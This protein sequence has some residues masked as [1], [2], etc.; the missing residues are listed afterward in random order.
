MSAHRLSECAHARCARVT[1]EEALAL[2]VVSTL[3]GAKLDRVCEQS[4]P[5][6]K[7][8]FRSIGPGERAAVEVKRLTSGTMQRHNNHRA[9]YLG[10]EPF[11]PAPTLMSTWLVFVDTTEAHAT[12]YGNARSPRLATLLA[13]LTREL[14][15]L[16]ANDATEGGLDP[17]IR[18]LTDSW[19]C[20]AVP[21]SPR[22]P[23][24][25]ISESHGGKRSTNIEVDVVEFL[26][27]WLASEHAE[28]LCASLGGEPGL[29]VGAL[30]ADDYGPSGGMIRTLHEGTDCPR[31]ALVM[32]AEIEAVVLIASGHVLDFGVDNGWRRHTLESL[33][34]TLL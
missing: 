27:Q 26:N 23:G 2:D 34:I 12:F 7:P 8:D 31:T 21:N 19:T 22:G 32:P 13:D 28:N 11:H 20:R 17:K 29:R 5:G 1:F 18:A 6:A 9:K 33:G 14:E 16:E 25:I 15:R 4:P 10:D 30:V 24:I 3:T